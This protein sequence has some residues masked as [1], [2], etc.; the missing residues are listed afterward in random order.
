MFIFQETE[1]IKLK[2]KC[3]QLGLALFFE[4]SEEYDRLYVEIEDLRKEINNDVI[5][6]MKQ[7]L[8]VEQ[9]PTKHVMSIEEL[10]ATEK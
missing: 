2:K 3:L 8:N 10:R 6:A 4:D 7:E 5:K 9:R 1:K